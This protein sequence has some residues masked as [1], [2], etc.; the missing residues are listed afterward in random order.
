MIM[1]IVVAVRYM[2]R[3]TAAPV[4][5]R[6]P[7]PASDAHSLV[8]PNN[9]L[10]AQCAHHLPALPPARPGHLQPASPPQGRQLEP[11]PL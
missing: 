9:L 5:W 8:L 11:R 10:P 3:C 6:L 4:E 2:W 1:I 7:T